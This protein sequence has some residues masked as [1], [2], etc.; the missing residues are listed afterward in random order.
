MDVVRGEYPSHAVIRMTEEWWSIR[1]MLDDRSQ[2]SSRFPVCTEQVNGHFAQVI[3]NSFVISSDL[4]SVFAE[5]CNEALSSLGI[6][7]EKEGSYFT[8]VNLARTRTSPILPKDGRTVWGLMLI[9]CARVPRR[10]AEMVRDLPG[11]A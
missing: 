1:L 10:G 9:T 7:G 2:V 6:G 11:S 4:C 3:G 5:R 8:T